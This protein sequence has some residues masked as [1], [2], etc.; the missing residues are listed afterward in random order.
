MPVGVHAPGG[1]AQAD[2]YAEQGA[3]IVTAA[4]DTSALT[5]AVQ[6]HLA[7]VRGSRIEPMPPL[8]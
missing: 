3:T 6:Q 2:R 8:P 5:D 7:L 1:G 4:V